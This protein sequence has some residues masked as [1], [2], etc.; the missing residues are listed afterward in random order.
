MNQTRIFKLQGRVRKIVTTDV[1]L[2]KMA[3]Y[4]ILGFL[5]F[6]TWEGPWDFG[7]FSTAPA[8]VNAHIAWK[9]D[10]P[11]KE[12][13]FQWLLYD[14]KFRISFPWNLK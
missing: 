5:P 9:Y 2:N 1:L 12:L 3:S 14:F 4:K 6:A 8:A 7:K 13:G 11:T 10:W